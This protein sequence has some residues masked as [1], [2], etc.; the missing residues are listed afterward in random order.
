[1]GCSSSAPTF[2]LPGHGDARPSPSRRQVPRVHAAA[3]APTWPPPPPP[4]PLPQLHLGQQSGRT[5]SHAELAQHKA[6]PSAWLALDGEVYDLTAF[7]QR[8][9]GGTMMI[10]AEAGR[11]ATATFRMS[12][13]A[14]LDP[15]ARLA[16]YRV[17]RLAD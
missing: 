6:A 8:H 5:V 11:D 9:P 17:G 16:A 10:L 1:M 3:V 4:P 15:H 7:A 2:E 13:A 12:H 14:S